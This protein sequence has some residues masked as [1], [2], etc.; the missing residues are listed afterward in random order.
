MGGATMDLSP[1]G[2]LLHAP[3]KQA[4]DDFLCMCARTAAGARQQADIA[5]IASHFKLSQQQALAMKGAGV[6]LLRE[7]VYSAASAEQ[8]G[9]LF[10]ADF[11]SDLRTLILH[12][13][14]HRAE[15]WRDESLHE[16]GVSALPRLQDTS[17]QVFRKP[18]AKGSTPTVLLGLELDRSGGHA[19]P[20]ASSSTDRLH[21]ELSSEQLDVMLQ[22]LGK[23]KDQLA[24]V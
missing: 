12:V 2:D 13:Y 11:H 1:L 18:T 21:I 24:Q 23:I 5:E 16:G 22:G 9:A 8:V 17:C 14:E 15:Q 19:M 6:A 10:P 20:A 4:V 3:S 7:A